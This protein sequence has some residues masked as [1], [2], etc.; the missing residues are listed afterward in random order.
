MNIMNTNTFEN[1]QCNPK[2]GPFA[3]WK[4]IWM[5]RPQNYLTLGQFNKRQVMAWLLWVCNF[6]Q[7]SQEFRQIPYPNLRF[8]ADLFLWC[9]T[10]SSEK[11]RYSKEKTN[12]SKS[13]GRIEI[14]K[15]SRFWTPG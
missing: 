13:L 5:H 7:T 8:S 11:L 14:C 9:L 12:R 3:R 6:S 10:K 1:T 4:L 15:A 2:S